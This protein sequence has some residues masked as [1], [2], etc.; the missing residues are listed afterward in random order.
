MII[1]VNLAFIKYND[2]LIGILINT[3]LASFKLIAF[4]Y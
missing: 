2:D 1:R 3:K 4:L